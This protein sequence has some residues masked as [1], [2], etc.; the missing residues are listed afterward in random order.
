MM[1]QRAGKTH[2]AGARDNSGFAELNFFRAAA[3]VLTEGGDPDG[4][5][6]FEQIVDH[7]RDGGTLT[8]DKKTITRILG[9]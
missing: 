8:S 1:N 2:S 3:E 6:Y 4:A 7:L 5:F 9:V